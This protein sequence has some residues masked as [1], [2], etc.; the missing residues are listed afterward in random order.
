MFT[1][2]GLGL[3][4][5]TTAVAVLGAAH[6]ALLLWTMARQLSALPAKSKKEL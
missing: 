1:P 5:V 6:T 4:Y 3:H 2:R